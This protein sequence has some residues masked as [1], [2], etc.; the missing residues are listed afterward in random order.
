W[1][2]YAGRREFYGLK[3]PFPRLLTFL[4]GVCMATIMGTTTLAF[5]FGG[6]SIVLVL[7]LLR[8]GTLIVAPVVDHIVGRQ[9]RWFSWAAMFISL[10]AVSAVLIDAGNYKLT[11]AAA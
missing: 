9:V 1:W 5:T 4:S 10:L 3:D 2:K 6:L 8:G 11:I 7:V